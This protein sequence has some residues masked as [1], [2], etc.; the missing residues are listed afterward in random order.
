[1][2]VKKIV[3]RENMWWAAQFSETDKRK[4]YMENVPFPLICF[5]SITYLVENI[6]RVIY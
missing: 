4:D 3:F 1:M 6:T 2:L 5:D